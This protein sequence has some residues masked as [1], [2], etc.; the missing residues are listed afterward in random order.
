M[1]AVAG[2]NEEATDEEEPETDE[3]RIGWGKASILLVVVESEMR[4][5]VLSTGDGRSSGVGARRPSWRDFT[6]SDDATIL[7]EGDRMTGEVPIV[8]ERSVSERRLSSCCALIACKGGLAVG[9]SLT[10]AVNNSSPSKKRMRREDALFRRAP[11]L[12]LMLSDR[13]SSPVSIDEDSLGL[14]V[15]GL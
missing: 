1:A 14:L 10:A 9:E 3:L 12:L 2:L 4:F 13:T 7:R 15:A 11:S 5:R 8:T 6:P